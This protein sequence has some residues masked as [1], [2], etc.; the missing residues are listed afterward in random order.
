MLGGFGT[1]FELRLDR[2]NP[3]KLGIR[4]TGDLNSNGELIVNRKMN[5]G[6]HH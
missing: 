4:R 5:R 1:A 2:M 3:D 6:L